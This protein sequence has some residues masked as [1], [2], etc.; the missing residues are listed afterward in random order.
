MRGRVEQR[1]GAIGKPPGGVFA[2]N[3]S[4]NN[5][6]FY[7]KTKKFL[8]VYQKHKSLFAYFSTEKEDY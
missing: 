1:G 8:L 5:V 7:K 3:I 4:K 6:L 2:E